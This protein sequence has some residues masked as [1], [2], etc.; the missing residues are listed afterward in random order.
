MPLIGPLNSSKTSQGPIEIIDLM[1]KQYIISINKHKIGKK[2]LNQSTKFYCQ[3]LK[4]KIWDCKFIK[5]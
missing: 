1:T 3:K 2:F 4:A 5:S